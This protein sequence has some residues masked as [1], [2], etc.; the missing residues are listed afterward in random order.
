MNVDE[1]LARQPR[2]VVTETKNPSDGKR[3]EV[4]AADKTKKKERER[5]GIVAFLYCST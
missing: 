5:A 2:M 4:T 1:L 3:F